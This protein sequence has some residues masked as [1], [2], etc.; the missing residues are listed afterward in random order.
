MG[1]TLL[2]L[3]LGVGSL[4][5]WSLTGA[6]LVFAASLLYVVSCFGVTMVFNVPLNDQLAAVD[7]LQAGTVWSR[8]LT[9][10]THWN[11]VRTLASIAAMAL[12]I[13]SLCLI[14][15]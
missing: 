7:P 4:F 15:P 2:C 8:Y 10:W 13:A 12:F 6:Q 3:G 1:A 11:H 9:V 14:R 5:W